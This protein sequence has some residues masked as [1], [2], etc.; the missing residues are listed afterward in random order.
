MEELNCAVPLDLED[1]I[2]YACNSCGR[3]FNSEH[4]KK[5]MRTGN[6]CDCG[7]TR[8]R[9]TKDI[10]AEVNAD[11]DYV[12]NGRYNENIIVPKAVFESVYKPSE[13]AQ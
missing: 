10:N 12:V 5:A 8:Y 2:L 3:I 13:A 7:S 6:V 11:G 1:F 4:E 9:P